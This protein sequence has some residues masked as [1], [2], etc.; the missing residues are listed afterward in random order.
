MPFQIRLATPADLEAIERF[1]EFGGSRQREI[2]AATCLVASD[3]EVIIGYASYDPRGLLGQ[4]L[5]GYLCVRTEFRRQGVATA[6]VKAVQS[7]AK[8]RKLI[9]STEDWCVGTQRIFENL[10]WRRLGQISD[11][12]KDGSTEWFYAIS[13]GA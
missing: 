8:G 1:D 3:R 10:G 7:V 4:P 11:V 2:A 5:L 6:L 9:S 12:N 13:L